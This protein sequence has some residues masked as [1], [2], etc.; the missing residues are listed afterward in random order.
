MDRE[1]LHRVR[2][3]RRPRQ[4]CPLAKTD[5][6]NIFR[7]K[8]RQSRSRLLLLSFSVCFFLFLVLLF[9]FS[10][11]PFASLAVCLYVSV[12]L[13]YLF[14]RVFVFLCPFSLV[15]LTFAAFPRCLLLSLCLSLD[16]TVS[17]P[18]HV[19]PQSG[20]SKKYPSASV[21]VE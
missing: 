11:S 1:C 12:T 3:A 20:T 13:S 4:I 8:S 16:T 7:E 2:P 10:L 19:L 9:A 15:T 21:I 5:P 14:L 17:L 18:L 6:V